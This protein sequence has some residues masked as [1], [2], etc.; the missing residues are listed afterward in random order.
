MRRG[1]A[2]G[3]AFIVVGATLQLIQL[4]IITGDRTLLV[5]GMALLVGYVFTTHYGLLV[6]GAILTGLGAGL[7]AR[8]WAGSDAGAVSLGLGL[9]FLAIPVFEQVRGAQRPS[10]WAVVPGSILTTI[11]LLL[12]ANV[13]G[14]FELIS[15][16]WPTVLMAIGVWMLISHRTAPQD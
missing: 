2:G 4:G 5:L 10:R 8:A 13:I 3:V 15:R 12:T 1:T 9:G 14:L 16:W 7:A 6:S 11:G